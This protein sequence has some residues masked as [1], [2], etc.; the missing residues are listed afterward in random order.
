MPLTNEELDDIIENFKA[1]DA[2]GDGKVTKEELKNDMKKNKVPEDQIDAL[3]E[4][5]FKTCDGD[6]DGTISLK[7][8]LAFFEVQKLE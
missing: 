6:S 1:S 4:Q 3:L 5:M 2:N 8:V 7:E